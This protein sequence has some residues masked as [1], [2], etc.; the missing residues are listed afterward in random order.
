MSC[1][2]PLG[3]EQLAESPAM[4]LPWPVLLL[5][6]LLAAA[7]FAAATWAAWT[8]WNA[9]Q[10][11]AARRRAEQQPTAS[12][13]TTSEDND[14][15]DGG[16]SPT[17]AKAS[18]AAQDKL[19]SDP[20]E[21]LGNAPPA[22]SFETTQPRDRS[23]GF[24]S[25]AASRDFA[26]PTG[27]AI[28]QASPF[29]Q[30]SS[31]RAASLPS[32]APAQLDSYVGPP[33]VGSD[34]GPP[35]SQRSHSRGSSSLA[36]TGSSW[37]TPSAAL[38]LASSSTSGNVTAVASVALS[39][40]PTTG[41]FGT[42]APRASGSNTSSQATPENDVGQQPGHESRQG[43]QS[44]SAHVRAR[45]RRG[46]R[47]GTKDGAAAGPSAA[48]AAL[49][50][51]EGVEGGQSSSRS[52]QV[53]PGAI[54]SASRPTNAPAAAAKI[55]DPSPESTLAAFR[56][57]HRAPRR[58][59]ATA[60]AWSRSSSSVTETQ[61]Q[62]QFQDALDT[63]I[64]S[65]TASLSLMCQPL[66]TSLQRSG[67]SS[68]GR[69]VSGIQ[70]QSVTALGGS[71]SSTLL[72]RDPG[73][74]GSPLAVPPGNVPAVDACHSAP[75]DRGSLGASTGTRETGAST[76]QA[77]VAD[78]PVARHPDGRSAGSSGS[79]DAAGSRQGGGVPGGAATAAVVRGNALPTAAVGVG[80]EGQATTPAL[81]TTLR[82]QAV[83]S[84]QSLSVK[85]RAIWHASTLVPSY[86]ADLHLTHTRLRVVAVHDL[87]HT[88]L[89]VLRLCT[90]MASAHSD[91][92]IMGYTCQHEPC[93]PY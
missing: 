14:G 31:A 52:Y 22:G 23:A 4:L 81:P 91:L 84:F 3:P 45:R 78:R 90:S 88:T 41:A 28:T 85:V 12:A 73:P 74:S 2:M 48:A 75:D 46:E 19:L 69:A 54:G 6:R 40:G 62:Q 26:P 93:T 71:S 10:A 30:E 67:S 65:S 49:P 50:S 32:S 77:P 1:A 61:H 20:G 35:G 5:S 79:P 16:A 47:P 39:A 7:I 57:A 64:D 33:A 66:F 89:H 55:R 13:D 17:S 24:K 27:A 82:Y 80:A 58:G 60:A 76:D 56:S 43:R 53:T 59:A 92:E 36:A 11:P 37:S 34:F 51:W 29:A 87:V 18:G 86:T 21:Q 8:S 44:G 25:H 72:G 70:Q 15:D 83:T 9:W 38:S 42:H 63:S 68:I